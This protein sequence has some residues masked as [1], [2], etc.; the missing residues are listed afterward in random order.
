MKDR[1]A[2][3]AGKVVRILEW[4]RRQKH[5][6]SGRRNEV[7]RRILSVPWE[8]HWKKSGTDQ[9]LFAQWYS[10]PSMECAQWKILLLKES[11][12]FFVLS[13]TPGC[14][15]IFGFKAKAGL[16]CVEYFVLNWMVSLS[17]SPSPSPLAGRMKMVC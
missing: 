15:A 8:P 6:D 14:C 9:G 5:M 17:L 12:F 7:P 4:N 16:P 13:S 2:V 3:A 10:S 11:A 1:K